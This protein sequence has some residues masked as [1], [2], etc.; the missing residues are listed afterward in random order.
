LTPQ[1]HPLVWTHKTGRKSL[2]LAATADHIVGMP[3]ADGRALLAR[4]LQ[5]TVQPDFTYSHEWEKGDL[6]IWDNC[7]TLHRAIPYDSKSGR[8]MHRTSLAG[9]EPLQ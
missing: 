6:V 2:V 3:R 1:E 7:G 5:W 8:E 4:L 9:E